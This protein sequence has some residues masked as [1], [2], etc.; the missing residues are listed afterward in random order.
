MNQIHNGRIGGTFLFFFV[1]FLIISVNLFYIQVIR[2]NFFKGLGKQQYQVMVSIEPSRA[3]IVDRTGKHLLALNKDSIAAFILPHQIEN[4]ILLEQFLQRYFPA[5]HARLQSNRNA[6]FLYIKRRLASDE[7]QLIKESGIADIKLLNEPSRFY[8]LANCASVI[9]I[10]DIDNKGL[11]GLELSCNTRLAGSAQIVHLEKDARS[12]YFYFEKNMTHEGEQSKPVYVT[13][14]SDL[15]FLVAQELESWIKRQEAKEGAV[16]ILDPE[17]GDILSMVNYPTFDPNNTQN[18]DIDQTK[19]S[20]I[21]NAYE[22]GSVFKVFAALAAL[23]EKVVDAN[24]LID[25]Q[26]IETTYIDGRKINTV[27]STVRGIIPFFEVIAVSN[28]IGI[29]LVAKRLGIDLYNHYLLLGFGKRTGICLPGEHA[30][31]VNPPSNWS[32]QSII[33]LSYGYEISSTLIQLAR[34]FCIFANG[35]YLVRPR[36]LLDQEIG[37]SNQLYSADTIETMRSILENTTVSG[38]AKRAAIKGYKIMSKTGTANILI[39]GA[40]DP[41]HNLYTCAGIVEKEDY[42]RVIVTFIK[43]TK[44][45]NVYASTIA[46]PLFEKVAERMLIHNK[47]V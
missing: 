19:N 44:K 37:K 47:I 30:G 14:D 11:L 34:A 3:S 36:I 6:Y 41:N 42:K 45:K 25:C 24:E 35:G 1:T 10:T 29:A 32:K 46:A 23:E 43:E 39:N 7:I 16:I 22:L 8:P 2:S 26:N 9:G 38:T 12:G 15:Q 21:A 17:H 33:S 31:F 5:A 20:I 13:L 27:K 40:Y 4:R 18:L 28:N